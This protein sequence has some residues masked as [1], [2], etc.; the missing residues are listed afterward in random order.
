MSYCINPHCALPDHPGNAHR[1]H[2]SSCGSPLVLQG[3]YRV[4][5]LISDKGGFGTVYLARTAKEEKILKVLKPEHNKNAKAVEL[6]RQ[7]A[8]VLGNLRHPGIPKIDGYFTHEVAD[9]LVLHC[10]V[11][12]KIPGVNLED[13]QHQERYKPIGQERALEWLKFLVEV[14]GVIHKK[15]YLHRDIK[16]SNIMLTPD[17]RLA[18][19]DFGTARDVTATYISNISQGRSMTAVVS[20]GYTAPEQTNGK[21][22]E[23]SDFFALARTFVQLLTGKHPLDMYAP[24]RD[25]LDWRPYAPDVT[26]AFADLLDLMMNRKPSDRPVNA[27][28]LLKQL[29]TI[30]KVVKRSVPPA[31]V[32][33]KLNLFPGAIP[34]K[35]VSFVG[36]IACVGLG[37][38]GG[39]WIGAAVG[40]AVGL[41]LMAI[42]A[43]FTTF[44][45]IPKQSFPAHAKTTTALAVTPDGLFLISAG[46]DRTVKVWQRKNCQLSHTLP[47]HSDWVYCLAVAPGGQTLFSGSGD[48][49]IKVWQSQSGLLL[50]T[51]LGHEL[52]VNCLAVA[53]D[54]SWLVSGSADRTVRVWDL[55]TYKLL[56]TINTLGQGVNALLLT[57]DRQIISCDRSIKVWDIG[58]N[59][60]VKTLSGH[61]EEIWALA[62]SQDSTILF[63][64]SADRT[65]KLWDLATGKL[66]RTLGGHKGE[67]KALAVHP[68]KPWLFTGGTDRRIGV[69]HIPSGKLLLALEGHSAEITCLTICPEGK[70]LYSGGGDGSVMVWRF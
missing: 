35:V 16:P 67:V 46:G 31:T 2:C 33:K 13:W 47:G 7:E 34:W 21:A 14:L 60:P 9:G 12:E 66:I 51:L 45:I 40:G 10:L 28:S 32:E 69:W 57:P 59:I 38:Y 62:L 43:R 25:C 50:E 27:S 53:R 4:E 5:G 19:I 17:G 42:T 70:F 15:N 63:S 3:K 52:G 54:E 55:R 37:W 23:Q 39:G 30:E 26:P 18:L 49:T 20:S 44:K 48:K 58:K 6:F 41:I 65:V 11:M 29:H 64:G 36:G 56:K 68:T 8:E 22:V 24:D 1:A 61:Q